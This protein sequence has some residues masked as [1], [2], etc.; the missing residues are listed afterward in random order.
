MLQQKQTAS[1]PVYTARK[2]VSVK[3]YF[4]F[5]LTNWQLV[6]WQGD[7][8]KNTLTIL[9]SAPGLIMNSVKSSVVDIVD[10]DVTGLQPC[11][12]KIRI[13]CHCEFSAACFFFDRRFLS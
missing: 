3:A 5:I 7:K 12:L 4:Y 6:R 10:A 1:G 8:T 13:S 11:R 9:R 2:I